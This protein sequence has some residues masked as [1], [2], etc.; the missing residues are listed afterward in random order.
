V[1]RSTS[2]SPKPSSE[3]IRILRDK[4][5]RTPDWLTEADRQRAIAWL[6]EPTG[7]LHVIE[8]EASDDPFWNAPLPQTPRASLSAAERKIER[9]EVRRKKLV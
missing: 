7:S 3:T 2:P 6:V 8:P 1:G 9:I 4:F 5:N